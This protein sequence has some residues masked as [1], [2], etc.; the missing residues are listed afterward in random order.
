MRA[1]PGQ[2]PGP[3]G[4]HLLGLLLSGRRGVVN[5]GLQP[6]LHRARVLLET[7]R[8]DELLRAGVQFPAG[9][10][11]PGYAHTPVGAGP[12]LR[13]REVPRPPSPRRARSQDGHPPVECELHHGESQAPNSEHEAHWRAPSEGRKAFVGGKKSSE[14]C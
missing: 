12:V 8:E 4:G 2:S 6:A 1:G 14:R 11:P 7:P 9:V 13:E 5:I 10:R 3:P